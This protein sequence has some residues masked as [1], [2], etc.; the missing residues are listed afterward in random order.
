MHAP[1]VLH[2]ILS[3]TRVGLVL[4]LVSRDGVVDIVL[5]ADDVALGDLYQFL[6]SRFPDTSLVPDNGAHGS[7]A[8]AAV[9]R[10]DGANAD[11]EAPI[12]LGW[13]AACGH[14]EQAAR[15]EYEHAC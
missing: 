13:S 15:V 7:W 14:S 1:R 12:D 3:Q 8:A 4:V 11:I 10:I 9:A 6:R 2:Y 5:Y